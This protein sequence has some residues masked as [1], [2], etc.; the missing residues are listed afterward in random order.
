MTRYLIP[1]LLA[2]TFVSCNKDSLNKETLLYY[3]ITGPSCAGEFR[4]KPDGDPQHRE[5]FGVFFPGT[6]DHPDAVFINFAEFP[7]GRVVLF[8]FPVETGQYMVNMD[9]EMT[10]VNP[11][12]SCV[13][14]EHLGGL[15]GGFLIDVLELRVGSD[16]LG[17]PSIEYMEVHFD[18]NTA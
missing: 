15:E 7:S 13:L 18:G 10:V 14:S 16:F 2:V 5:A 9:L 1:V 3:V 17:F 8:A 11:D 6:G 4:I 12:D